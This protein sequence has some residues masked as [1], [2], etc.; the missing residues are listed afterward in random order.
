MPTPLKPCQCW[1]ETW[2]QH[3][4]H[5]CFAPDSPE[6]CHDRE[7]EAQRLATAGRKPPRRG[8][9]SVM[10]ARYWLTEKGWAATEHLGQQEVTYR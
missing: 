7:A 3:D 2:N 9:G 4:G 10:A 8:T 5:C 1:T 6:D